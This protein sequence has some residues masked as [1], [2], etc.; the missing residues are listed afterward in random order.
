MSG[1]VGVCVTAGASGSVPQ[2]A[3]VGKVAVAT[4]PPLV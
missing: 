4:V 2:T 3:A 1:S